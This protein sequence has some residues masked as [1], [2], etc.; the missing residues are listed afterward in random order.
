MMYWLILESYPPVFNKPYF[1]REEVMVL[2]SFK[3]N[4]TIRARNVVSTRPKYYTNPY[5]SENL[6]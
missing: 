5:I 2:I 6:L 3:L 1:D 4:I